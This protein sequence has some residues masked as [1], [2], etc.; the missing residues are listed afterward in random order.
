MAVY[1]HDFGWS[2]KSTEHD[3]N[4]AIL[5]SMGGRLCATTSEILV[6]HF[7]RTKH[8]KRIAP[9]GRHIDVAV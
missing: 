3:D 8:P 4:S 7:K 2:L 1:A 6:N 9:F 5:A